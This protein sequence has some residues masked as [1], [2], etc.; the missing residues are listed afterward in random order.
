M[1]AQLLDAFDDGDF[2][3]NPT[4]Q[5]DID[6]FIVNE[7]GELQLMA[8][9][10]GSSLLYST[11]D[12]PESISM[13]FDFRLEMS[14]STS[15]YGLIYLGLDN[16]DVNIANGY[17]LQ[18]GESG[19]NDAIKL[20]RL[21]S[22]SPTLIATGM[23][24][25]IANDPAQAHMC[26]DIFPD[27]LWSLS[28]D[29]DFNGLCE[30]EFE[31]MDDT[32][33]FESLTIFGFHCFYTETRKEN[34][35]YDNINIKA[36]EADVLPPDLVEV[37]V[38]NETA[39]L[40]TFDELLDVTSAENTANYVVNNN[41]GS[42]I[43]A[44][45]DG[46]KVFLTFDTPFVSGI[47]YSIAIMNIADEEGNVL[48]GTTGD[49]L[50]TVPPIVGDLKITEILF[51]PFSGG[52]D[53]VEIYNSSDKFLNL[54]GTTI[55]NL[56]REEEKTLTANIILLPGEYL[57]LTEDKDFLLQTYP[58]AVADRI[59]EADLPAWNNDQGNVSIG[60][61]LIPDYIDQFDY[62]EDMH[63]ELIDDTEGV[64]LERI[65]LILDANI[66]D[67]FHSAS[68]LVGYATPGRFNSNMI[69]LN[70]SEEEFFIEK[71]VF[72]PN[73]DGDSDFLLAQYSL[74][75]VGYVGTVKIF[76]DEGFER[77]TLVN[78]ELLS[79][80]GVITWDGSD[81]DGKLSELGMYIMVAELFHPDGETKNFSKVCVLAKNID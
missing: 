53:F 66:K 52:Q 49:F 1:N 47:S 18:L 37:S 33:S 44:V 54:L 34:F 74:D 19:S 31:L 25:A 63:F 24:G 5:G 71:K 28:A 75:K 55:A 80:Q 78:N 70:P 50:L 4:W 15:N 13:N 14:P 29:Y 60:H 2:L 7:E 41:G 69:T 59:I 64:S 16:S 22:G 65:S 77:K 45:V 8:P 35:Y 43:S 58:E 79:T 9:T 36:Y 21:D 67:N 38:V 42:P 56:D 68:S 6:D 11:V 46:A 32:Y 61:I 40:L 27:G 17:Y 20:Y 48:E 72:S 81:A 12:F 57:C 73:G 62:S 3:N 30:F 10:A 23:G 51:D 76:D 39:L 26:I